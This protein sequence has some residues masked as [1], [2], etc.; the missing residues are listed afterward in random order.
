MN[1]TFVNGKRLETGRPHPLE[2]GDSVMF[3]TVQ[4]RFELDLPDAD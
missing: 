1:G 2:A 3:G 4:C